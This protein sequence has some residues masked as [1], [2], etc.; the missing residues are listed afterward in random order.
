MCVECGR[1]GWHIPTARRIPG[2]QAPGASVQDS[3]KQSNSSRFLDTPAI[4]YPQGQGLG[5]AWFVRIADSPNHHHSLVEYLQPLMILLLLCPPTLRSCL[6]LR[7]STVHD[8][9]HSHHPCDI[10][11]H[12]RAAPTKHRSYI[13]HFLWTF[14]S[15]AFGAV[16]SVPL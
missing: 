9:W 1:C 15:L 2:Q 6:S 16:L 5:S 12:H 13:I 11:L 7:H 14:F 8:K 4:Y 10:T 3:S